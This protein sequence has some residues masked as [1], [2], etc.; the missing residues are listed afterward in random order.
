MNTA[1]WIFR[2]PTSCHAN[3][4]LNCPILVIEKT[5]ATP[6][7]INTLRELIVWNNVG[8]AMIMI[9]DKI[10]KTKKI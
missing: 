4:R 10:V 3:W 5:K 9:N 1:S 6:N 2:S 8:I 7:D